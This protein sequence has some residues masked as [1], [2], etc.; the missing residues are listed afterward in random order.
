MKILLI[1]AML[2]MGQAFATPELGK[3]APDFQL[4]GHDGKTYQLSSLK[5]QWVVLEWFNNECPYVEKHYNAEF[6]NMQKLQKQW[7]DKGQ[8][9]GTLNWFAVS[10]SAPGKQGHL[11]AKQAKDIRDT[12]RKAHMTAIL[13]DESGEVGK[14]YEA[15]T[16]PHMFIINP[17]GLLV[18]NG[19]ID[20]QPSARVSSLKGAKNYVTAALTALFD[21][22]AVAQGTTKPYGCSVKYKN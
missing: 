1:F 7:I 4:K 2:S 9:K 6:Q 19:A 10:S 5:G 13:L 20:D 21:N 14:L 12:E 22:K 8:Q 16:T 11:N 15:K 17:K 18:Y 3:T